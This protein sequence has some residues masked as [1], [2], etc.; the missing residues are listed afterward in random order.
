MRKIECANHVTKCYTTGLY[1]IA[2]ESAEARRLLSVPRIKRMTVTMRTIIRHHALD[3]ESGKR[4]AAECARDLAH[5]AGNASFHVL[6]HHER[7][8]SFYCNVAENPANVT[9]VAKYQV[10]EKARIALTKVSDIVKNKATK[11]VIYD[12]TSNLAETLMSRIAKSIG[13]KRVNH[14][15]RRGYQN[16][17]AAACLSYQVGSKMHVLAYKRKFHHSPTKVLK[18]HVSRNEKRLRGRK[19]RETRTYRN[20]RRYQA[21]NQPAMPDKEYGPQSSQ[22]DLDETDAREFQARKRAIVDSLTLSEEERE[23]LR[24]NTAREKDLWFE[25]RKGRITASNVHAIFNMRKTTSGAR[26]VDQI[27]YDAGKDLTVDSLQY[28]RV[29]EEIAIIQYENEMECN[30]TRPVGLVVHKSYPFLAATPDGLI[31]DDL[32]LEVKCPKVAEKRTIASLARGD[33]KL[34]TFFFWTK[35]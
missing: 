13:G 6:G 34:K 18:E 14:Y 23:I 3:S 22:P 19:G 30:V 35:T 24:Q 26:M 31:N 7:C 17:C 2:K 27:L 5:D 33:E 10:S 1:K 12:V 8:K 32:I 9:R 4:S 28:G 29:N 15:Q 20:K 25:A 11:L 16:R 21:A